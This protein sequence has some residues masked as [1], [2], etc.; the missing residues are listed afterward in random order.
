MS[1]RLSGFDYVKESNV[2][3]LTRSL[4]NSKVLTAEHSAT[5]KAAYD[6]AELLDDLDLGRNPDTGAIVL[7]RLQNSYMELLGRL[8]LTYVRGQGRPSKQEAEDKA[9]GKTDATP[10]PVSMDMFRARA[11]EA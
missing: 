4:R 1:V 8:G 9:E 2:E 11:A 6:M 5:I 10:R 3:A 7:G